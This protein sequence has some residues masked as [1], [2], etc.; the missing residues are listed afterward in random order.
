M[1]DRR[2]ARRRGR[3][4]R[5]RVRLKNRFNEAVDAGYR[6]FRKIIDAEAA[7]VKS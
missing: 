4:R 6:A 7:K 5:K 3:E 2:M 1:S